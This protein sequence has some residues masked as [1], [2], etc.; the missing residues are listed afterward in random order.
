MMNILTKP[1]ML[2]NLMIS[3]YCHVGDVVIDCTVGNGMDTLYLRQSVGDSGK[4]YGFDIQKEAIQRTQEYLESN[5][6]KVDNVYLINDSHEH[7]KEYI[8]E[9]VAVCVFNLGYLPNGNKAVTT[10][11]KSTIEAIKNCISLLKKDGLILIVAYPGHEEGLEETNL[12]TSYTD[13]LPKKDFHVVSLKMTN[14]PEGAPMI[15]MITK[16]KNI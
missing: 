6:S 5:I 3:Q 16:K 2:A 4:V 11:P 7:V 13:K 12:V 14:Q 9:P 1:T 8:K 15:I 10:I